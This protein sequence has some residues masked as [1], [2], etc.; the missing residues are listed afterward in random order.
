MKKITYFLVLF[1]VTVM[2]SSC[3]DTSLTTTPRDFLTP[4]NTYTNVNGINQGI[5]GLYSLVRND[6]YSN[7]IGLQSYG[8]FGLG[9]DWCID[10]EN[11]E[12]ERLLTSYPTSVTPQ[13]SFI[14][15][16]WKALYKI[17]QQTNILIE[18][19]NELSSSSQKTSELKVDLA[20]ARFFRAWAYRLLVT[21]WGDVPL[22]TKP[23]QGEKDDF[24]RAPTD[25]VYAQIEKDLNYAIKNLPSPISTGPGKLTQGAAW[26]LL[27][28]VYL[29]E[30]KYKLAVNAASKVIDGYNYHLMRHLFGTSR[31]YMG[32]ENVYSDLFNYG[33]QDNAEAIWTIQFKPNV[34]GNTRNY[35]SGIF[36]PR[37]SKWGKTPDGYPAIDTKTGFLDSLGEPV[38]RNRPTNYV[39]YIIWEND[40]HDM[41]NSKINIKRKFYF[42]SPK[43]K[44]NG[45]VMNDSLYKPGVRNIRKD[46]MN[47]IFPFFLKTFAPVHNAQG[48]GIET[49]RGG[50]G[51][52]YTDFYAMRLAGT[53]LLRA[54]AY[55]DLGEKAKAAKDINKVRSRAHA[56]P[57]SPAEVDLNYILDE[58]TRELFAEQMRLVVLIRMGKLV[59][60]TRKY[61]DNP[62]HPGADIHDYNKL[63]PIP[64]SEID[65]NVSH[66]M[67]QN[68]GYNQ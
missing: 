44:Y 42:Y 41:R 1:A 60:R 6:F 67:K 26:N 20:S 58:R 4:G 33:N 25:T 46:T 63:L 43:S 27:T 68:P 59:E 30:H 31:S 66:P 48:L 62:F 61:N 22:V 37:Y 19:T 16:W 49:T 47:Y 50:G 23:I 39:S 5:I 40:P 57:V 8:L 18:K 24:T 2:V 32:K 7:N 34:P 13:N 29:G 35:W 55:V 65:L 53:Y 54:E 52:V 10:G 12:G 51:Q 14:A 64:Q 17:V 38:A 28:K 15:G 36:G 11:P 3:D 21:L 56:N 9:T 45:Y